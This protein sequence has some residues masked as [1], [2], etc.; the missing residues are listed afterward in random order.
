MTD[1]IISN[2]KPIRKGLKVKQTRLEPDP[3]MLADL[4]LLLSLVISGELIEFCYVARAQDG[5]TISNIIIND[6]YEDYIPHIMFSEL[7]GLLESYKQD[8]LFPVVVDN[9]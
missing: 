5:S 1:E 7:T 3:I 8:Y 4:K 6:Q 9:E 2:V